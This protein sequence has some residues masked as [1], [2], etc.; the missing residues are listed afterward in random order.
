MKRIMTAATIVALAVPLSAM[1]PT[2]LIE[3]MHQHMDTHVDHAHHLQTHH[4]THRTHTKPKKII[5]HKST[6]A[7]RQRQAQ[8]KAKRDLKQEG[9]AIAHKRDF[10]SLAEYR[11]RQHRVDYRQSTSR[12]VG[13]RSAHNAHP[14]KG[15]KQANKKLGHYVGNGWFIDDHGQYDE[16]YKQA[17]PYLWV[18]S[19]SARRQH[20]YRH[21][22]RQWYLTYLYEHAEFN[23]QHGFHYGYYDHRG[24]EFDTK[25][26]EYDRSYTYQDRLHGKGLFEHRFYRPIRTYSH[27]AR[28]RSWRSNIGGAQVEFHW[29][30]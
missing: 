20:P 8:E 3:R 17:D 16:Q 21:Y 2:E 27:R 15:I 10:H 1:T 28:T 7:K 24:F 22:R 13:H 9:Y 25:F 4:Q 30:N 5:I 23:D 12:Q 18:P 19:R 6:P 11:S 26:Y 29:S 14:Q